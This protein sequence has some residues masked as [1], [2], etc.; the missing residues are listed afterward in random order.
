MNTINQK[1]GYSTLV[2]FGVATIFVNLAIGSVAG[3]F[4][5]YEKIILFCAAFLLGASLY[6]YHKGYTKP[7][8]LLSRSVLNI[9]LLLLSVSMGLHSG[10]F[11]YHIP[12]TIGS[13]YFL[14]EGY[15]RKHVISYCLTCLLFI[16]AVVIF[17]P[18]HPQSAPDEKYINLILRLNSFFSF[19]LSCIFLYVIFT[20]LTNQNRE[21]ARQKQYAEQAAKSKEDFLS[22]M[23]HELRTPLNGIIG[24]VELLENEQQASQ[25]EKY[26]EVLKQSST[27][28]LSLVND[29]LDYSKLGVEKMEIK[30]VS[31][32]LKEIVSHVYG[33]FS[34]GF[35]KKGIA[36]RPVFDPLLD[37]GAYL[38][39]DV[40]LMQV[41]SNLLSN[42]LK[43]TDNGSVEFSVKCISQGE[44]EA[45]V[46][47]EV[48]D[49]GIGIP[50]SQKKRVFETYNHL[51]NSEKRFT[52]SSGLGLSITKQIIELMGGYIDFESRENEGTK[53]YFTLTLK[54]DTRKIP[55]ELTTV[56]APAMPAVPENFNCRVLIAEDNSI[57]MMIIR[58][59]LVQKN[60]QVVEATNGAEALE[61]LQNSALP[62]HLLLLDLHLP[63]LSGHQVMAW[64][65]EN[66]YDVPVIAF[67]ANLVDKNDLKK[68][69]QSGFADVLPKPYKSD[70]LYSKV[71]KHI[72]NEA[73]N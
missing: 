37:K 54:K 16:S 34:P 4:S 32:N 7:A 14:R 68:L 23:S 19:T 13:I 48:T 73:L 24:T 39:D 2:Y 15:S 33:I 5:L 65:R 56:H 9:V 29:L 22:V 47:F 72:R 30:T 62:F 64:I 52:Q 36:F 43:Y 57:N 71:F 17:S 25:K 53:F 11:L 18:L 58:K 60:I 46:H 69:R 35:E 63:I 41:I 12:F 61:L 70:E 66:N 40:R 45:L 20:Y 1:I 3:Y 44:Q 51:L 6:L 55:T 28:M 50:E 49:T 42:A 38:V 21:L 27:H 59:M 31:R 8:R 10:V 67:T 26:V